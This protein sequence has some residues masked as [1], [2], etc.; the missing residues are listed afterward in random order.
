[1][2][3]GS[4]HWLA[5]DAAGR[6]LFLIVHDLPR[7][8]HSRLDPADAALPKPSAAPLARP[9]LIG[10]WGQPGAVDTPREIR[11]GHSRGTALFG[12]E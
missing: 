12:P 11:T 10:M 2:A 1:L 8:L 5:A 7:M 3:F 6:Q 4:H 9:A